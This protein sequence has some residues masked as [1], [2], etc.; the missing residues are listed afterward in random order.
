MAGAAV[1]GSIF[2]EDEAG[3]VAVVGICCATGGG[4]ACHSKGAHVF[5]DSGAGEAA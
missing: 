1:I 2:S 5:V 4:A 3:M